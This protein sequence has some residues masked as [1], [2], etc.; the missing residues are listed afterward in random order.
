MSKIMHITE[1]K[2]NNIKHCKTLRNKI[3]F[4]NKANKKNIS[5]CESQEM[6]KNEYSPIRLSKTLKQEEIISLINSTNKNLK[7][8]NFDSKLKKD[9]KKSNN[10]KEK[11]KNPKSKIHFKEVLNSKNST[12]NLNSDKNIIKKKRT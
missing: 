6:L 9:D 1:I 11:C 12:D 5:P 2:N 3:S 7:S 8:E 10:S 4:D